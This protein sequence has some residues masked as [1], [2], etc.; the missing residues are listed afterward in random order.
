[1]A[2]LSAIKLPNGTTYNL[3]DNGALQLTGGSVTGPVSFGN[4]VSIDEAT[5]GDLVVNG[6]ASFTNNLQANTINGVTVGSN[7]KFT[8][9]NTVT[10]ATTTGSG[11]AV[12]AITASNGALTI[13][14]GTTFLTSHQNSFGK[15]SI[16]PGDDGTAIARDIPKSGATLTFQ[17]G[18]N[19]N[20]GLS[21]STSGITVSLSATDTTYSS[22]A[23]ASGGTAVSLVT[24][25]EKYTWNSKTS[26]TGTITSVKTTA[27]AHTAIN[28]TSG[29][30]SFN[31]PTTAA[32]VG[33][34]FGYT[35]S[36]N[37]RAVQQ[38]SSG[39]L[40]VTQKDD[41]SNTTYTLTNALSSHKFTWTLTAGGS[42]S[43]ST[44]TT[45]ELVAGSNITLT[46]DTTNKKITIAATNTTYSI[47]SASE[48]S[49][50]TATT[51]RTMSAANT[52]AG[53]LDL[54]YPVGSYYETSDT[55]FDPNT[56][57]GGTWHLEVAGQVHVSGGTDY[58][59]N[60]TNTDTVNSDGTVGATQ[61]GSPDAIIPYHNH[62]FNGNALGTHDHTFTGNALPGHSHVPS[63][64]SRVFVHT[65]TGV[66]FTRHS[67]KP[68]SSTAVTNL[69]SSTQAL[70]Y[71]STTNSVSGG[72]PSGTVVG[73][74]AGTPSGTIT[75]AGTS[76]EEIGAN[77]Q[78]YIAV[79]RWHRIA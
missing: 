75:Y 59:V 30:V 12:T 22:L 29:A 52:K 3:K 9:T 35:T 50:G 44:T 47:M 10:T 42:G 11:N 71:S 53:L 61:D 33:I 7:P 46:D 65:T 57:W 20:M 72:T 37:N 70:A 19:I 55:T 69:V 4:S 43:G 2:N 78:P 32:H 41:N 68:G 16:D 13:T 54:F 60:F 51:A 67:V 39:N 27:G 76:G 74:S 58:S 73:K 63:T 45:A 14:K 56:A 24:T 49:T 15:V 26:N 21:N 66:A 17:T 23:A 28:V 18:S 40:Y 62:T 6:S 77:M 25:G 36:G 1:M 5:V 64:A 34:K 48:L 8:D 31:V 38:D 79:N